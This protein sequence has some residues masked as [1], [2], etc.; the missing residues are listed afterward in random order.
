M[1]LWNI[2]FFFL[3]DFFAGAFFADF[4]RGHVFQPN[5]LYNP[6][7]PTTPVTNA[8]AAGMYHQKLYFIA[9]TINTTASTILTILSAIPTF[10]PMLSPIHSTVENLYKYAYFK[11]IMTS[12]ASNEL[13]ILRN[14]ISQLDNSILELL[15]ERF[16]LTDEVGRIKKLNNISIENRDVEVKVLSRVLDKTKDSLSEEFV[17]RLY[18]EIFYESKNR[19]KKI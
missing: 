19:Q 15:I 8:I 9:S 18:S 10:W 6:H 17:I 7:H 16:K 12:T 5:R 2:Y 4:S 14:K 11:R 3:A 13:D 1:T